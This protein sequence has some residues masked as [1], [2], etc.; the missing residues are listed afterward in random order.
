MPG[1]NYRKTSDRK[2]GRK[3]GSKSGSPYGQKFGR[4]AREDF[5]EDRDDEDVPSAA[6]APSQR[7]SSVESSFAKLWESLFSSP[8]HLDSALSK[9]PVR[10]KSILAQLVPPVLLRPASLAEKMGIGVPRDEPWSLS[11]EKKAKWRPAQLIVARSYTQMSAGKIETDPVAEDYPSWMIQEWEKDWGKESAADLVRLLAVEPPLS[12]RVSSKK[13]RQEILSALTNEDRLPVRVETSRFSPVGI[14]LS[15]YAPVLHT[16]SF[17]RGEFE[18]QD[19]GSQVLAA[20]ALWPE[21]FKDLLQKQPGSVSSSFSLKELPSAKEFYSKTLVDACAGAGG[22]SLAMG[23]LIKGKG[24]IF[25]YDVSA[26]KLQALKRRATRA[27]LNNIK[28]LVLSEGQESSALESFKAKADLVLVDAPCSGWGVLRRNPDIKWRQDPK[29][30][31]RMPVLQ[32][33]LLDTYSTLVAPGGRLVYGLCT[34]RRAETIAVVENF[35]QTHPDFEPILGGFVGPGPCDG[36]F[37]YSW[38]KK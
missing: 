23:D 27:G 30:L 29:V 14:R 1:K 36:F 11:S 8:I 35:N 18:I 38:K 32:S 13:N 17:K 21:I 12:L 9:L 28:T 20:F 2:F 3:F 15:G 31:E 19:E 24:R 37:M 5:A 34:F 33:R 22:K 4:K 7:L 16:E 26:T 25:S 10:M 6:P